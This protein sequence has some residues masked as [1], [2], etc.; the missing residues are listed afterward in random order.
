MMTIPPLIEACIVNTVGNKDIMRYLVEH[1]EDVNKSN[2]NGKTPLIEARRI[3]NKS[4]VKY[5]MDH[6]AI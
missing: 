6:G 5:F 4:I 3:Q 2:K 1:G